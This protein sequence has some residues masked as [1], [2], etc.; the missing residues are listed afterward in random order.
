MYDAFA[1]PLEVRQVADPALP[2]TGVVV[3]VG[4][5]G[6]CRSDWHGWQG[7][8]PEITLPHVPGHELAGTVEAI[9]AGVRL[10]QVG[11]RVTVPFVCA[12]GRCA[13]CAAGDHQVCAD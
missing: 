2:A 1:G 3:R 10:W 12:C 8:D 5:S 7:H 4:A 11:D 9:G 6:V 13:Q